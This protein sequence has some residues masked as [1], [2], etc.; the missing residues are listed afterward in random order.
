MT[1]DFVLVAYGKY[2][3]V[4]LCVHSIEKYWSTVDYNIYVVVNYTDMSEIER[5]KK[6]LH[7]YKNV[8]VLKGV[9]QS[10]TTITNVHGSI[11]QKLG[12]NAPGYPIGVKYGKIDNCE[13]AAG[14][15]YGAWAINMGIKAGSSK[16]VCVLD[17]DTIF[18]NS[19]ATKL[20]DNDYDT[21]KFIS[22][23]W[24]PAS[25]FTHIQSN[26]WE[27]GM[28]RPMLLLC[29]RSLYDEIAAAQYVENDIWTSS[30]WNCDYRDVGGQMTWYAEQKKYQFKILKNSYRDRFRA[31]NRLWE[32]HLIDIPY[33]EQA[34]LDDV[35]IFFH[36]T[37]SGYRV[38]SAHEKWVYE[39]EKYLEI[40]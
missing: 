3:Y 36:A 16:Y 1:I 4:R 28:A 39:V 15:W 5:C 35:P 17:H 25:V 14:G 22:N 29:E 33:G 19:Y 12:T 21:V 13:I 24:C 27:G 2:D 26:E 9:D 11:T 20:L 37:R 30:P 10:N 34:W 7:R 40:E 23:R 6:L 38:T 18:L 31:D 8:T 32:E